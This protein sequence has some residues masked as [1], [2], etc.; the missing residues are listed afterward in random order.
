MPVTVTNQFSPKVK[1][2]IDYWLIVSYYL[3]LTRFR[4]FNRFS[5]YGH[6]SNKILILFLFYKF[7]S[8]QFVSY[9]IAENILSLIFVW[10]LLYQAVIRQYRVECWLPSAQMLASKCSIVSA[11][12]AMKIHKPLSKHHYIEKKSP[13]GAS[14]WAGG[15]ISPYVFRND[16]GQNVTVNGERYRDMIILI[17]TFPNWMVI[18]F[19]RTAPHSARFN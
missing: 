2:K 17:F 14:L 12:G 4:I 5:I 15:I 18:I 13:S 1:W 3:N 19:S 11:F 7:V 6:F 9:Q 8:Y 10:I 16:N